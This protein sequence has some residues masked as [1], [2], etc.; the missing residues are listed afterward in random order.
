MELETQ[1]ITILDSELITVDHSYKCITGHLTVIQHI[2]LAGCGKRPDRRISPTVY[3]TAR[4]V[5]L[6]ESVEQTRCCHVSTPSNDVATAFVDPDDC[7][8]QGHCARGNN[9]SI[10]LYACCLYLN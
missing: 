9:A 5:T 1:K 2:I 7:V 3:I 10:A 4:S 6:Q 8:Q